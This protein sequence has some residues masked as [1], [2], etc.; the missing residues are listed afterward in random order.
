VDERRLGSA[1]LVEGH[2]IEL[3][4]RSCSLPA[5]RRMLLV[6]PGTRRVSS[7]FA[8]CCHTWFAPDCPRV[9]TGSYQMPQDDPAH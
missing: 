7:I 1:C 9:V 6:T 2:K 5:C 4:W 8:D 3:R